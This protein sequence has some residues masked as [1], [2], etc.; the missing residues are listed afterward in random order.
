MINHSKRGN[1]MSTPQNE[2]QSIQ[3]QPSEE[4]VLPV[5]NEINLKDMDLCED[6]KAKICAEFI[7]AYHGR[8]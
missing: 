2:Y 3:I 4:I 6:C 5:N 7:K 1:Y 8:Q